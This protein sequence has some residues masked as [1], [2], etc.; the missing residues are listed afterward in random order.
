MV[1]HWFFFPISRKNRFFEKRALMVNFRPT[2][3]K[4]TQNGSKSYRLFLNLFFSYL[5]YCLR[6]TVCRIRKPDHVT[7]KMNFF[8]AKKNVL[9]SLLS[10]VSIFDI[11]HAFLNTHKDIFLI[12]HPLWFFW[13][14]AFN[15]IMTPKD[16]T[17]IILLLNSSTFIKGGPPM[18][19]KL[20][21][22]KNLK[23]RA[24]FW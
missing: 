13:D 14:K 21:F 6:H 3:L 11:K 20:F 9:R 24:L 2:F 18:N 16:Q 19:N 17:K 5:W 1:L 10:S 22:L 12:F 23:S 8:F 15:L 4:K 7:L